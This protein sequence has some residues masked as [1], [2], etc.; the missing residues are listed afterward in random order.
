[1]AEG[2]QAGVW[3]LL[4]QYGELPRPIIDYFYYSTRCNTAVCPDYNWG[5]VGSFLP[6]RCS[7]Q[8]EK[9]ASTHTYHSCSTCQC[10]DKARHR[11]CFDT[12]ARLTH[13]RAR[14]IDA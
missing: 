11:T 4:V 2:G 10:R 14:N 8:V 9:K 7:L 1:M 12:W 5:G 3:Y 13:A 6:A